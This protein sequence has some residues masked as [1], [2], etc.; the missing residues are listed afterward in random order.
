MHAFATST[1]PSM[2]SLEVEANSYHALVDTGTHILGPHPAYG[3][4]WSFVAHYKCK[5]LNVNCWLPK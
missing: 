3:L 4:L 1:R 5:L 2:L